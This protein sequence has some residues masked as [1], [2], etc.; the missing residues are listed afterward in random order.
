M[1]RT[2]KTAL[3]ALRVLDLTSNRAGAYCTK[4]LAGFG[5]EV[6]KIEPP[7]GDPMRRLPPFCGEEGPERSIP[8][9]WL[10]TGKKSVVLDLADSAGREALDGW[11]RSVDVVV[12]TLPAPV[13]EELGVSW[14][15]LSRH[16]PGLVLT[17]VSSFGRRGP[18]AGYQAEEIALYAMSGS[19]KLTGDPAREPLACGPS[20]A[21]YTAGMWA[22]LLTLTALHEVEVTGR[23]REIDLS[24]HESAAGQVE[25]SGD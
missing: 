21:S 9:L 8:F 3:S 20:V 13:R 5:A 16:H 22:Y 17:S 12:E 1:S 11:L 24:I 7:G 25:S 19:M 23:G 18:Y 15:S 10:N 4:L 6:I 14:E 2:N